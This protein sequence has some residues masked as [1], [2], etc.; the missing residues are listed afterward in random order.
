MGQ[1]NCMSDVIYIVTIGDGFDSAYRTLD[2][3]VKA[4]KRVAFTRIIKYDLDSHEQTFVS[5][6]T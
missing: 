4:A 3:A 1:E 2:E 5:V 6:E